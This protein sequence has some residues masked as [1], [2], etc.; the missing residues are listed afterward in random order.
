MHHVRIPRFLILMPRVFLIDAD[1]GWILLTSYVITSMCSSESFELVALAAV[2]SIASLSLFSE[3]I[4]QIAS[5]SLVQRC[6]FDLV[7]RTIRTTVLMFNES[8]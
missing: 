7:T 8:I 3:K 5:L 2:D 1:G 4:E 6:L